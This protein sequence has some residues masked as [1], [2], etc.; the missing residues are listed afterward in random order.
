M[1]QPVRNMI[2]EPPMSD[3]RHLSDLKFDERPISRGNVHDEAETKVEKPQTDMVML[4]KADVWMSQFKTRL[5]VG[6]IALVVLWGSVS[7]YKSTEMRLE[8]HTLPDT[9]Q[10]MADGSMDD[11]VMIHAVEG[12]TLQ[13]EA[14]VQSVKTEEATV[15][16]PVKAAKAAPTK[17]TKKA[18]AQKVLKNK[19]SGGKSPSRQPKKLKKSLAVKRAS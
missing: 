9:E 8:A 2:S 17:T 19:A 1:G 12:D 5:N 10:I 6:I 4:Q 3:T 14:P 18:A 15:T 16:P 11:A 7:Y 13:R